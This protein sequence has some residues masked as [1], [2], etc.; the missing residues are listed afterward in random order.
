MVYIKYGFKISDKSISLAD[1]LI[2]CVNSKLALE[3]FQGYP[4]LVGRF[5]DYS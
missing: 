2:Y 1:K 5:E 4:V 3:G